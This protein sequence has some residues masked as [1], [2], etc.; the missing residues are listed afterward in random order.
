MD[1]PIPDWS[2]FDLAVVRSI[3]DYTLR[4]DAFLA[5]ATVTAGRTR[6]C[7][8]PDVL[9]WNTDETYLRDLA[10]A[11]ARVDLIEGSALKLP[12]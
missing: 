11:D 4:R 9:A 12:F 6:L 1:D 5:W 8:N 3:W 7:N 10:A 2:A